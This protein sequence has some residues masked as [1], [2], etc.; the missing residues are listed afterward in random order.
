MCV[1]CVYMCVYMCMYAF[2]VCIYVC[3]FVFFLERSTGLGFGTCWSSIEGTPD[4]SNFCLPHL[5]G[6]GWN[7]KCRLAGQ[8]GQV[9]VPCSDLLFY[10]PK[11]WSMPAQ[12]WQSPLRGISRD[13]ATASAARTCSLPLQGKTVRQRTGGV[14]LGAPTFGS[15]AVPPTPE[16]SLPPPLLTPTCL[17]EAL[18]WLSLA[19]SDTSKT[20]PLMGP[21]IPPR[22]LITR[23]SASKMECKWGLPHSEGQILQQGHSL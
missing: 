1:W 15:P 3:A 22:P 17:T 2:A 6:L 18:Q 14:G 10:L 21:D 4:C 12:T 13:S 11:G 20:F 19:S 9:P 23:G 8:A 16:L 5:T 7:P